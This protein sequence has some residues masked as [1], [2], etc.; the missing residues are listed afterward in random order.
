VR[1]TKQSSYVECLI[2]GSSAAEECREWSE[3]SVCGLLSIYRHSDECFSRIGACS[4]IERSEQRVACF[5]QTAEW[6]ASEWKEYTDKVV[7]D[8]K[9]IEQVCDAWWARGSRLDEK[10]A[11]AF[12]HENSVNGVW[13]TPERRE[14][15]RR[16]MRE[17]IAKELG[18][19]EKDLTDDELI[20][21]VIKHPDAR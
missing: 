21:W 1:S 8:L 13:S 10:E 2:R 19:A 12:C 17:R 4:E 3:K 18:K 14:E 16:R 5:E 7:A 11:G 20:D 9:Y 6:G 15:N